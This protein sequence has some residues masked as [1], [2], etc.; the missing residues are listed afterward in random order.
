M[1]DDKRSAIDALLESVENAGFPNARADYHKRQADRQNAL[2]LQSTYLAKAKDEI[3]KANTTR[4]EAFIAVAKLMDADNYNELLTLAIVPEVEEIKAKHKRSVNQK[5][6]KGATKRN[7]ETVKAMEE[8]DGLSSAILN[9]DPRKPEWSKW[10]AT[11]LANLVSATIK[12]DIGEDHIAID[13]LTSAE[14]ARLE[15]L[16]RL[17]FSDR[18]AIKPLI[19][20]WARSREHKLRAY[21]KRKPA[22]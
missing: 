14:R 20:S 1:I 7:K 3:D 12:Q 4:A 2:A 6:G 8:L 9:H 17:R 5:R 11:A 21:K 13:K 16:N 18:K 10:A 19:E 15:R 22:T